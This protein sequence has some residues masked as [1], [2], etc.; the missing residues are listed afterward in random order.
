MNQ[1]RK[2]ERRDMTHH[3]R[4]TRNVF[5]AAAVTLMLTVSA[6]AHMGKE[7]ALPFPGGSKGAIGGNNLVADSAGNIYGTTW[8]GGNNSTSCGVWTGVPGYC[9]S[10]QF[11]VFQK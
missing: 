8:A 3:A 6:L 1:A 9:R 5:A 7:K 4:T 11:I 10:F 2:Q